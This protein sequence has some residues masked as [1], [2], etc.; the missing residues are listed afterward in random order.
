[1][2]NPTSSPSARLASG[3]LDTNGSVYLACSG[4]QKNVPFNTLYASGT[5]GSGTLS[6]ELSPDG[7]TWF[8]LEDTLAAK[9]F[10]NFQARFKIARLTLAG[11][12]SASIAFWIL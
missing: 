11:A 6:I 5:F 1:M 10:I 4:V 2:S 8:A 3:T 9:G 7:N 12:S